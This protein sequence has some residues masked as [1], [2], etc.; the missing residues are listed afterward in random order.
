MFK[1]PRST[2]IVAAIVLGW[3]SSKDSGRYSSQ[4]VA[5]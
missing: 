5:P 1:D 4:P 3:G 2:K